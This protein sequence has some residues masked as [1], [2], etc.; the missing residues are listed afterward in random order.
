MSR[1]FLLPVDLLIVVFELFGRVTSR[2]VPFA[3]S[4]DVARFSFAF[5]HFHLQ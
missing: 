4:F 3:V 2:G 5:A 1:F